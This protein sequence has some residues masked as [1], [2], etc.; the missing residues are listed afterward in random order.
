MLTY[1]NMKVIMSQ[2]NINKA[3]RHIAG[4]FEASPVSEWHV[5]VSI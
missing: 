4:V 3:P 5:V 2:L 1:K